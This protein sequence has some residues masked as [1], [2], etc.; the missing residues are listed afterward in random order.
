MARAAKAARPA[1]LAVPHPVVLRAFAVWHRDQLVVVP[2]G[3]VE[4][5]A[6]AATLC[7]VRDPDLL[8]WRA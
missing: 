4:D 2:P 5:A 7:G 6:L 8:E 3:V 1:P